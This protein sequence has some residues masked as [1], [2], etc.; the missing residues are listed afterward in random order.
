MSPSCLWS[1]DVD[2]FEEDELIVLIH[3]SC[4][5]SASPGLAEK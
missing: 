1:F 2:T 5:S 3:R 4:V